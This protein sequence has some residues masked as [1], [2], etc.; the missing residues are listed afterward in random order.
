MS[1]ASDVFAPLGSSKARFSQFAA[2]SQELTLDGPEAVGGNRRDFVVAVARHVQGED[3]QFAS[4]QVR[5]LDRGGGVQ[6][7]FV[8]QYCIAQVDRLGLGSLGWLGASSRRPSRSSLIA[9]RTATVHS[10]EYVLSRSGA[11]R[12]SCIHAYAQASSMLAADVRTMLD[13]CRLSRGWYSWKSAETVAVC[14]GRRF[15]RAT[16]TRQGARM[17]ARNR[18]HHPRD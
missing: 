3:P 17:P 7:L 1:F 9:C 11:Q 6:R 15:M 12:R 10:H 13:S 8:L 16:G 18:L 2:R 14:W 5:A 4:G